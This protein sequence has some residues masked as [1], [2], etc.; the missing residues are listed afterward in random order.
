M[1][2]Q[3]AHLATEKELRVLCFAIYLW[4]HIVRFIKIALFIH[5][6]GERKVLK[7]KNFFESCKQIETMLCSMKAFNE[8]MVLVEFISGLMIIYLHVSR[9]WYLS[10]NFKAI[11]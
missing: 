6:L 7:N 2:V 11:V 8:D 4:V 9:V 5:F 10:F 1:T 3:V